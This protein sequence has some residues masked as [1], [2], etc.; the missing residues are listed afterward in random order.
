M[1]G[2]SLS[3]PAP[4]MGAVQASPTTDQTPPIPSPAPSDQTVVP[5]VVEPK[6]A[7]LEAM[8]KFGAVS[9]NPACHAYFSTNFGRRPKRDAGP[10]YPLPPVIVRSHQVEGVVE[11][12]RFWYKQYP[13]HC[14]HFFPN[15]GW[16]IEDLWDN[17]DIHLHSP[18]FLREVLTFITRD[19]YYLARKYAV[20]WSKQRP[21]LVAKVGDEVQGVYDT[22]NDEAIVGKIFTDGDKEHFPTLFLWHVANLMR[23]SMYKTILQ[24]QDST[25]SA[26][27]TVKATEKADGTKG[28]K[29]ALE[30]E[31]SAER[32]AS[33]ATAK[34]Q[35][36]PEHAPGSGSRKTAR[37][38][39]RLELVSL[40]AAPGMENIPT[41]APPASSRNGPQAPT[42]PA[43][44]PAVA[45][46]YPP[47]QMP[48][49][50]QMGYPQP[51]GP[52]MA[53]HSPRSSPYMQSVP[54]RPQR[55]Q[56]PRAPSGSYSNPAHQR[57]SSGAGWAENISYGQMSRQSSYGSMSATQSPA[58]QPVHPAQPM[59]NMNAVNAMHPMSQNPAILLQSVS[60]GQMPYPPMMQANMMQPPAG[61]F[62]PQ[63]MAP[64]H[65][66]LP[67]GPNGQELMHMPIGN[68][69]N[70][71]YVQ[72]DPRIDPSMNISNGRRPSRGEKALFNPYPSTRPDFANVAPQQ[73][74]R[75]AGRNSLSNGHP[76]DRRLSLGPQNHN[77]YASPIQD[78]AEHFFASSMGP[79][80]PDARNGPNMAPIAAAKDRPEPDPSVTGDR[81]YGCDE[82]WIGPENEMVVKL[83]IGNI[84]DNVTV[85]DV[86]LFFQKLFG[87][88]IV[89]FTL[90]REKHY[91]WVTFQS[92]KDAA[93][94][95]GADGHQLDGRTIS[96]K[97]PHSYY[98]F[99]KKPMPG[100]ESRPGARGPQEGTRRL[101]YP[102]KPSQADGVPTTVPNPAYSPQD[103][104]STIQPSSEQQVGPAGSPGARK[105]KKNS[106]SPKKQKREPIPE[107]NTTIDEASVP[108]I[109]DQ[110]PTVSEVA[111]HEHVRETE[112]LPQ[113][114]EHKVLPATSEVPASTTVEDEPP[115]TEEFAPLK[116]V[117][118]ISK[119]PGSP[120][121]TASRK[122]PPDVAQTTSNQDRNTSPEQ[123]AA[124]L[125]KSPEAGI[126]SG[127]PSASLDSG[128]ENRRSPSL[129][130]SP[131]SPVK[132]PQA[133]MQFD[134][135]FVGVAD[136]EPEP[137]PTSPY[138]TTAATDQ[139]GSAAEDG[140]SRSITKVR[141]SSGN[142]SPEIH[143]TFENSTP[144]HT[145]R[146][147]SLPRSAVSTE[148][149]QKQD[150]SFHSAQESQLEPQLEAQQDIPGASSDQNPEGDSVT[151]LPTVAPIEAPGKVEDV[152]KAEPITD[153]KA[154]SITR[155]ADGEI[156]ATEAVATTPLVAPEM[157]KDVMA[158]KEAPMI[159]KKP[160][161]KQ[162]E[163]LNP[164]A[165]AKAL[166]EAEKKAKKREKKKSKVDKGT[167]ATKPTTKSTIAAA[168][169]TE[170]N[171]ISPMSSSA[172]AP[173][174]AD[175][176]KTDLVV[177]V[178]GSK[179]PLPSLASKTEL[180][181]AQ[182]QST[183]ADEH[184]LGKPS[185]RNIV[186]DGGY[187]PTS[188]AYQEGLTLAELKGT[189]PKLDLQTSHASKPEAQ[190]SRVVPGALSPERSASPSS[191]ARVADTPELVS[192]PLSS[193]K[194]STIGQ[195][196]T[197][198]TKAARNKIAVPSIDLL[199]RN[200]PP[201]GRR[202][203]SSGKPASSAQAISPT[204]T[205]AGD[206]EVDTSRDQSLAPTAMSEGLNGKICATSSVQHDTDLLCAIGRQPAVEH[207]DIAS[208]ASEATSAT[209]TGTV[210]PLLMSPSPTAEH[211]YTPAQTPVTAQ[212]P[213]QSQ[214]SAKEKQKQKK[215]T[216]NREAR[217]RKKAL[218]AEEARK[219]LGEPFAE[220]LAHITTVRGA[221]SGEWVSYYDFG[222]DDSMPRT[223]QKEVPDKVR[224]PN[225]GQSG[226]HTK[227]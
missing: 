161:P 215:R 182:N 76:R 15:A 53:T 52:G 35:S 68:M 193:S 136:L 67:R 196:A 55:G 151:Q 166:K 122:D 226:S 102:Q 19:N 18:S 28:D 12:A 162:T 113:R 154:N 178:Q 43:P 101:S 5:A 21:D 88:P 131:A 119:P 41:I 169:P 70:N 204:S 6:T 105:A 58:F 59:M 160:G 69:T 173:L 205:L 159:D 20:D 137:S 9:A 130:T 183:T 109:S 96:V 189:L 87:I 38:A 167:P 180:N 39:P 106:K 221:T 98:C 32:K 14:H 49:M 150:I 17:H 116:H 223:Q 100:Y 82:S 168:Q 86:R 211:F 207:N 3:A 94:A 163:S 184:A 47:V 145:H 42:V 22:S 90:Q 141:N 135:K 179:T 155:T 25:A 48:Q 75:K 91:G 206:N 186:H 217:K 66:P 54:L 195:E 172:T 148:D 93:K 176:V 197:K 222:R 107:E 95:L 152:A 212:P 11:F 139:S 10:P 171:A 27:A 174:P 61:P 114:T 227:Q 56:Y 97:V 158:P 143:A 146:E 156:D 194:A 112:E 92:S 2:M 31:P 103:V 129:P 57:L 125:V 45:P 126:V 77:V 165:T 144:P 225:D 128:T 157:A 29:V 191:T 64:G 132:Q 175:L 51:V 220:Q 153:N 110:Q 134:H 65:H 120:A 216:A 72:R 89:T 26:V 108:N 208:V 63:A 200:G 190:K 33:T 74:G 81:V 13:Y 138:T 147:S 46:P 218:E 185:A 192:A 60:N 23:F 4:L 117:I 62:G 164:F 133:V 202:S 79:R 177:G 214:L 111:D 36:V 1:A 199:N 34:K 30:T 170:S 99:N 210:S 209:L 188:V 83:W 40:T 219:N 124:E 16:T 181:D 121:Q 85:A 78:Q 24:H 84:Q 140:P 213:S 50:P 73:M 80:L 44:P 198:S 8:H 7:Y 118:A 104:R 187:T 149:D 71:A 142:F 115:V 127:A 224:G 123:A 201:S 37:N 203:T